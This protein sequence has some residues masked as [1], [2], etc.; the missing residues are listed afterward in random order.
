M[1]LVYHHLVF[2]SK[3]FNNRGHLHVFQCKRL[4]TG[5]RGTNFTVLF[6][7]IYDSDYSD[8]GYIM[9]ETSY[10]ARHDARMETFN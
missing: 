4:G 9:S 1:S 5:E 8:F 2:S 7:I 10:S 3:Q 6:V